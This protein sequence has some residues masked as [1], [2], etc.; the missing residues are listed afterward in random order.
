MTSWCSTALPCRRR[1][2]PFPPSSATSPTG[3]CSVTSSRGIGSTP[4]SISPR[5]SRCRRRSAGPGATSRTTSAPPRTSSRRWRRR[6]SASSL[7]FS[8]SCAVYGTPTG[9]RSPRTPRSQPATPYG[10]SKAMAEE[11]LRWSEAGTGL[12]SASLRYF[13]AAGAAFD[14]SN[15]ETWDGAGNLIP[16]AM[17]AAFGGPPLRIHGADYDTPDG[18]AV[19]DYIHVCRSRDGP[20]RHARRAGRRGARAGPQ[21]RPRGGDVRPRG[22]RRHRARE[23]AAAAGRGCRAAGGGCAC[24][25]RG[26]DPR[27]RDV[28]M[29]RGARPRRRSSGLGVARYHRRHG[30][31]A[32]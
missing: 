27:S 21:P 18:T 4:S 28:G 13:N 20:P 11:I 29:V 6:G 30:A 24:R 2:L 10:A 19:R 26:R 15:G 14:A 22:G 23:R 12:R 31:D 7:L 8:S 25:V 32:G 16:I 1:S 17:H 5:T 9:C 3:S